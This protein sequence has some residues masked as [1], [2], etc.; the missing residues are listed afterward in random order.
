MIRV[1]IKLRI[2][3]GKLLASVFC[4]LK[5]FSAN[6]TDLLNDIAQLLENFRPGAKAKNLG[7]VC[8]V[9]SHEC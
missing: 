6:L 4:H 3:H 1:V 2:S 9:C 7:I 8:K 5:D